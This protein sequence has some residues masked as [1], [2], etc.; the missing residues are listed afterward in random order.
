MLDTVEFP[1]CNADVEINHD[2]GFGYE[3]DVYHEIECHS[4]DKN[5]IFTTGIIYVFRPHKADCL[6]DGKHDYKRT[7][8]HPI[9]FSK[10][11]CSMC[12]ETR[13]MTEKERFSFGIG[14]KE[15][16]FKSLEK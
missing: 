8:T 15:D 9:E 14:T 4:C 12:G 2:D 7:M 6:N 1:Y 13:E 10:M 11:E 5:F 3:E 16:Y